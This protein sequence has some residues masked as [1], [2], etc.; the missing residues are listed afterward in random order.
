MGLV[1]VDGVVLEDMNINERLT[2]TFALTKRIRKR[3][4]KK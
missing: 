2:F 1:F 3:N 4:E